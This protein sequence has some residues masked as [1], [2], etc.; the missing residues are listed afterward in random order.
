VSAL[1]GS[2]TKCQMKRVGSV[3]VLM[4]LAALAA[5]PALA[6]ECQ[7]KKRAL[8]LLGTKVRAHTVIKNRTKG[9]T[10]TAI[11]KKN[12]KEKN[13]KIVKPSEDASILE[14][15]KAAGE[16]TDTYTVTMSVEG[17][18][19]SAVCNY[20]I[21]YKSDNTTWK[22]NLNPSCKNLDKPCVGCSFSC[23]KSWNSD[24]DRWNTDF[25]IKG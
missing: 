16:W 8:S 21:Y 15:S 9:T 7:E 6:G 2:E 11:L 17:V 1:H 19:G 3:V 22:L 13:K 23:T 25:T 20:D 10:F 4:L 24:K 12:G 18:S 14:S 5:T